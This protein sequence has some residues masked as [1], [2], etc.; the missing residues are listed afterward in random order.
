MLTCF[1]LLP[2]LIWISFSFTNNHWLI[3]QLVI[4]LSISDIDI[5]AIK[6][7]KESEAVNYSY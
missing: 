6:L 7:L 3:L 5:L 4:E 2:R 1:K